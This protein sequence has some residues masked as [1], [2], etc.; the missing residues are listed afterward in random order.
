MKLLYHFHLK[1]VFFW[2][3]ELSSTWVVW[4]FAKTFCNRW[5]YINCDL[6]HTVFS[7]FFILLYMVSPGPRYSLWKDILISTFLIFQPKSVVSCNF[8]KKWRVSKPLICVK[9]L[10]C[11]CW[12]FLT[13]IFCNKIAAF[14]KICYK[15]SLNQTL[16]F[17]IAHVFIVSYW[18]FK[19]FANRKGKLMFFQSVVCE[20]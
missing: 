3:R 11:W 5:C 2:S 4:H 18:K 8:A 15:L 20:I 7:P 10:C 6:L 13:V 19:L 12:I 16:L 1:Y 9:T 17:W 14:F